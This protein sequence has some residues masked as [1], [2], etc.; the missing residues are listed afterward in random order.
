MCDS[1]LEKEPDDPIWRCVNAACPA[2]A[3]ERIIHYCS[4]DAMDIRGLG[5]TLIRKFFDLGLLKNL[6]SLYTL[7]WDKISG[8]EGFG[9]KRVENLK[10][11]IEASKKQ[12][13]SRVLFGLG[14]LHVGEAMGKTLAA[15][16]ENIQELY[17]FDESRLMA[18]RDVGPKVAAS[19]PPFF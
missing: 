13:L 10:A 7:E 14:I 2:Q 4:K 16:V 5:D 8:M 1:E 12:P 11:A 9:T 15:A 19:H 18:L 17:N 3:V 6:A